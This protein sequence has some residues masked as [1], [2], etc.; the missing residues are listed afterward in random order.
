M[1]KFIEDFSLFIKHC[2]YSYCLE[3]TKIYTVKIDTVKVVKTKNGGICFYQNVKCV[4]V[5]N[6]TFS[7]SKKLMNC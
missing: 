5:R 7:K 4:I 2:L 3:C 1:N 6:K